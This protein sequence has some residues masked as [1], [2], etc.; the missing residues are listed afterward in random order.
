MKNKFRYVSCRFLVSVGILTSLAGYIGCGKATTSSGGDVA[1]ALKGLQDIPSVANMVKEN[2]AVQSG[3]RGLRLANRYAVSGTPPTAKALVDSA[4]LVD[5]SFFNGSVAAIVAAQ[6]ATQTQANDYWQGQTACWLYQGALEGLA[7]MIEQG[8]SL[9]YM[10]NVPK[11]AG[12]VTVVSGTLPDP[13]TVFEQ[14]AAD[15]VVKISIAEMGMNED[16]YIK[17]Y[18]SNTVGSD[19]YKISLM[20]CDGSTPK[21]SETIEVN[22]ST[23]V[24]SSTGQHSWQEGQNTGKGL[25]TVL[26]SLKVASDGSLSFDE[27]KDRKFSGIY[28]GTWG[29]SK[30]EVTINGSNEI[31]AD[32]YNAWSWQENSGVDKNKIVALFSGSALKNILFY[33]GASSG[34]SSF[35]S[36]SHNYSGAVEYQ[37]TKYVS[38]SS[39]KYYDEIAA[40]AL[41]GSFYTSSLTVPTFTYTETCAQTPDFVLSIDMSSSAM[42]AVQTTCEGDRFDGGHSICW[43][44]DIQNAQGYVFSS[45]QY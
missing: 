14:Q 21:G 42:K 43:S 5:S 12:A 18:G 28:S 17:V 4:T 7:R 11:Q 31:R 10:K 15:R 20:F 22:K 30:N 24:Y 32:R 37:N 26:A 27:T 41:S 16:I 8:T 34:V 39:G 9:C 38:V 2:T 19:V 44:Q 1:A 6:S 13:T 45:Q 36:E 23:K 40:A 25:D 29:L 33:E 35:G 3:Y